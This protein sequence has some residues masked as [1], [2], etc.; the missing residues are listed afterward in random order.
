MHTL[1]GGFVLLLILLFRIILYMLFHLV[2]SIASSLSLSSFLMRLVC[3]EFSTIPG[4]ECIFE[5]LKPVH[6]TDDELCTGYTIKRKI[7]RTANNKRQQKLYHFDLAGLGAFL[8]YIIM[9]T[10]MS[11]IFRFGK[12]ND[13]SI[14]FYIWRIKSKSMRFYPSED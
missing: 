14:T 1:H 7:E 4:L 6:H 9:Y 2:F 11:G 8:K 13:L 5:F 12:D 3:L 10:V